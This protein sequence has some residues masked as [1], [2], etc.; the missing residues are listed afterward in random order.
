M[1]ASIDNEPRFAAALSTLSDTRA[2]ARDA[3]RTALAGLGGQ[4][5]LAFVFASMHHQENFEALA[6][7]LHG[8]LATDCLLGCTG[9]A[10]VGNDREIENSPAVAV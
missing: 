5:D 9:E 8:D 3:G 4:P 2:A 7:S 1:T 10:I 6:A